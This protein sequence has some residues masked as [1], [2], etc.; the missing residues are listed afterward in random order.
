MATI[1]TTFL[2]LASLLLQSSALND[3]NVFSID[4]ERRLTPRSLGDIHR[5]AT[6]SEVYVSARNWGYA[7][8]ANVSIGTPPQ[9]FL[10][11]LDTGSSDLWVPAINSTICKNFSA[12]CAAYGQCTDTSNPMTIHS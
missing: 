5:R 12:E 1:L 8:F 9:T 6:S 3:A 2:F 4:F 7:Y 11:S 10:V